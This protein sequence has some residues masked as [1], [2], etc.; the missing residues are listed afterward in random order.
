MGEFPIHEFEER[1]ENIPE[2]FD[3]FLDKRLA[4]YSIGITNYTDE[5]VE[6]LLRKLRETKSGEEALREIYNEANNIFVKETN[7]LA[8]NLQQEALAGFE[9]E[10]KLCYRI[11]PFLRFDKVKTAETYIKSW[12]LQHNEDNTKKLYEEVEDEDPSGYSITLC[13][14]TIW[15][16]LDDWKLVQENAGRAFKIAI[17]LIDDGISNNH[18]LFLG[19]EAA[20]LS[21][22]ATRHLAIDKTKE[23]VNRLLT[24]LRNVIDYTK[25]LWNEFRDR[26]KL[27]T[28]KPADEEYRFIHELL[29]IDLMEIWY[30]VFHFGLDEKNEDDIQKI[31]YSLNAIKGKLFDMVLKTEEQI[32]EPKNEE[33]IDYLRYAQRHAINNYCLVFM[34]LDRHTVLKSECHYE[35]IE[36]VLNVY[37]A[38]NIAINKPFKV[39]SYLHVCTL[40][41][42][43][44]LYM[45]MEKKENNEVNSMLYSLLTEDMIKKYSRKP[46]E[47][48]RY[49]FFR[50]IVG[51]T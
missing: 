20:Y 24:N 7:T 39:K 31:L 32:K 45:E 48:K 10:D 23:D 46:Y 29:S 4:T 26:N 51:Y 12:V 37:K 35:K 6:K 40:A 50:D 15:A 13:N 30:E 38:T 21:V 42:A 11:P 36:Y 41:V 19:H 47:R 25:Y 14:A 28:I 2:I 22:V 49:E 3:T 33:K 18:N 34:V 27:Q 8:L 17:D 44:L 5:K 1:I 43:S 9:S 16:H